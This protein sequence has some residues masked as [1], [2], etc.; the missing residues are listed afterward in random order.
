MT[1]DTSTTA[2]KIAVMQAYERGEE[3]EW[4]PS[5]CIGHPWQ[6]PPCSGPAWGWSNTDYRIKPRE[7]REFLIRHNPKTG[8]TLGHMEGPIGGGWESILVREVIE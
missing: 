4:R 1:I 7:P 8:A 3:I 5:E 2:G 6:S